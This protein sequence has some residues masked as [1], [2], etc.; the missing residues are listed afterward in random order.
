MLNVGRFV[1]STCQRNNVENFKK[2]NALELE[3]KSSTVFLE[4]KRSIR[5]TAQDRR[6]FGYNDLS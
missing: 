4:T 3:I 6:Y 1:I 5:H 2:R